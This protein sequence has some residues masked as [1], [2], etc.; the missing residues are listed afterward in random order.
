MGQNPEGGSREIALYAMRGMDQPGR[1]SLP[2]RKSV[3][4][5][6]DNASCSGYLILQRK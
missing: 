2:T 5:A 4:D 3:A 1:Y 6:T